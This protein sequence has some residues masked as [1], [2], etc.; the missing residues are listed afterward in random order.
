MT[1]EPWI[2]ITI[3]G[4]FFQNLRSALQKRST[5]SLSI[6]GA[7]YIRF[8]FAFP[9]AIIY[10]LGLSLFGRY[11]LPIPNEK[12]FFYC[13]AG[14]LAQI[15]FTVLLISLFGSRNFAVGTVYSKTEIIQ[16]ALLAYLILGEPLGAHAF[17]AISLTL[18][19]VLLLT[20]GVQT[21]SFTRLI[22]EANSRST[23][24]GLASGGALGASVVFYRGAALS[25]DYQGPLFVAAA[26]TLV[27]ALAFQTFAMG[28]WIFLKESGTFEKIKK[29]WKS[30]FAVGV[31]GIL[32]SIAWFTAFTIHS[33][34]EV[35]A[36]GQIE[37]V[38]TF[39]FSVFFF[40]E[41]TTLAEFAGIFFIML[42][43]LALILL[44]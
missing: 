19:G 4:A 29:H 34:A 26:F 39:L 33:A 18:C 44:G 22:R 11:S 23:F 28:A 32:A 16:V 42:G 27:V 43:V 15:L 17:L 25:L 41:K 10:L 9:F 38:F 13:F 3:F 37:L 7:S 36:L 14:G 1:I 12:F 5:S 24:L 20:V 21:L 40:K 6:L 35:R 31:A 2:T 8:L 30:S